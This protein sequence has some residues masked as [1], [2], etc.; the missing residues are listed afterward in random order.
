[1]LEPGRGP[2]S[3]P[4]HRLHAICRSLAEHLLGDLG[5]DEMCRILVFATVM[6]VR[7]ARQL[8]AIFRG[9]LV[10]QGFGGSPA[11]LV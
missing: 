8:A 4:T 1:M 5:G 6:S 7:F 10:D 3:A 9:G 11:V 2:W